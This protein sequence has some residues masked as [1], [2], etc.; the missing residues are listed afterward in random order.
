MI[1][2]NS[3]DPEEILEANAA[4]DIVIKQNE[5]AANGPKNCAKRPRL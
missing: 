5:E 2:A 4:L 1:D 3:L